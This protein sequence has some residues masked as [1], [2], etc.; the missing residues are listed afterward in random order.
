M[1]FLPIDTNPVVL[2]QPPRSK[3]SRARSRR[4]RI[5]AAP[6]QE[7]STEKDISKNSNG[8]RRLISV[9]QKASEQHF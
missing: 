6:K 8:A 4:I 9:I 7:G 1:L 2:T 5:L 3:N